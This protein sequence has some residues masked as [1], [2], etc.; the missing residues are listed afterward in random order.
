MM[1][2]RLLM[3]VCREEGGMMGFRLLL[4]VCRGKGGGEG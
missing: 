2:F 1:G 4:E 3:E